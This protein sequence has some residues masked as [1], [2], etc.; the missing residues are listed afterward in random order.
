MNLQ[1]NI[2]EE[3]FTI[4]TITA[5]LIGMRYNFLECIFCSAT[6]WRII[7]IRTISKITYRALLTW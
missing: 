1:P 7:P 6:F 5:Y 3:V 4:W 2:L